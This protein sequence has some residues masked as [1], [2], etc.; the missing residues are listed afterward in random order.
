MRQDYLAGQSSAANQQ[1]A[2]AAGNPRELLG[3]EAVMMQVGADVIRHDMPGY[4]HYP[5]TEAIYGC[6]HVHIRI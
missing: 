4:H 3:E 5:S 6:T 1:L 2:S